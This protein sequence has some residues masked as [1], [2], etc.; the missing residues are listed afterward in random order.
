VRPRE[1]AFAALLIL[2][3][4][5]LI[6]WIFMAP[7][8]WILRDGLGP[9]SVESHGWEA[10]WHA[11]TFLSWGPIL[12]ALLMANWLCKS[13]APRPETG[14]PYLWVVIGSVLV[15]ASAGAVFFSYYAQSDL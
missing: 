8:A 14:W 12:L 7:F 4:A 2:V 6:C 13:R 15:L 5:A 1:L 10:L 9:D 3:R 11:F